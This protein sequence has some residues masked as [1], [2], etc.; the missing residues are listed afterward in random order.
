MENNKT[1]SLLVWIF[2]ENKIID[3]VALCCIYTAKSLSLVTVLIICVTVHGA[4]L[5]PVR[6]NQ[7]SL[8]SAVV[9]S[10][11]NKLELMS[12]TSLMDS[13]FDVAKW[14]SSSQTMKLWHIGNEI[15]AHFTNCNN[16]CVT[17]RPCELLS[18]WP[19][20]HMWLK[21]HLSIMDVVLHNKQQTMPM[22]WICRDRTRNTGYI[23]CRVCLEDFQTSINCTYALLSL[24][25]LVHCL[26]LFY[27]KCLL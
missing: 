6:A 7:G 10:T 13:Q 15:L 12:L 8:Q 22:N 26:Y 16:L 14:P 19:S 18:L 24:W 2:T 21:L 5:T 1:S 9:G 3:N 25:N 4:V 17:E 23:A 27:N 11:V 20:V